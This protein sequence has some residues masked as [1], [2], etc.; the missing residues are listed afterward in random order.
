V[1]RPI[2]I[3][4]NEYLAGIGRY[5]IVTVPCEDKRFYCPNL[6]SAKA[7]SKDYADLYNL[8]VEIKLLTGEKQ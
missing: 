7:L 6:D 4:E 5:Y 8:P 2:A 3:E 1:K